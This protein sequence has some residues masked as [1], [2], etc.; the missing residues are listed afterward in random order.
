MKHRL[1]KGAGDPKE[2]KAG[3][4]SIAKKKKAKYKSQEAADPEVQERERR[5][6]RDEVEEVCCE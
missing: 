6:G 3:A 5:Q 4:S 2:K 1:Q